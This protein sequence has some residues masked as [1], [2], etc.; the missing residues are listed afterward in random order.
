MRASGS[1]GS[2]MVRAA[3]DTHT[4][5]EPWLDKPEQAV[6]C[7]VEVVV[8]FL[9]SSIVCCLSLLLLDSVVAV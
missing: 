6:V 4:H 2:S 8:A 1:T 9:P 5:T 3:L 7:F